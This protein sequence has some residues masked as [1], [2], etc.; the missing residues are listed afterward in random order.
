MRYFDAV[1]RADVMKL[2][3]RHMVL[4][5]DAVADVCEFVE[6]YVKPPKPAN[7]TQATFQLI[8][9]DITP[10]LDGCVVAY[11]KPKSTEKFC[12]HCGYRRELHE[13]RLSR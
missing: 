11:G 5:A 3:A 12:G 7:D 13:A 10:V 6:D 1:L 9:A 8:P 2:L 4:S